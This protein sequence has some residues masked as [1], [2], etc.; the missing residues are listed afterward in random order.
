MS[1]TRAFTE[2]MRAAIE[3]A[4]SKHMTSLTASQ[5]SFTA[6]L[7]ALTQEISTL[8]LSLSQRDDKIVS[9]EQKIALLETRPDASRLAVR[10]EQLE[11]GQDELEQYGR[12]LNIRL[13][14]VPVNH[15]ESP[16]ALESQVMGLLKDAGAA[17][18]PVDVVRLHRATAPRTAQGSSVQSSQLIIRLNNW[19][20]R[21]S[22]H[23]ARNCARVKGHPIKQDLTR[24]RR[25]LISEA[26]VAIRVWPSSNEPVY[27]YANINC[28]GGMR[29]GKTVRRIHSGGDLK[30]ALAFFGRQ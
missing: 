27:C 30:S 10:I 19:R 6:S 21:E 11:A 17:I 2:E 28:Q 20:A 13:E 15:N 8:K 1:T 16:A 12:R 9:L 29:R 7:S 5:T 23:M 24:F 25:E 18:Q 26:N 3:C 4:I 22:A 14:N